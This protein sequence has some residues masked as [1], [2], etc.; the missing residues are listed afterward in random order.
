MAAEYLQQAMESTQEPEEEK[1]EAAPAQ[2]PAE[3]PVEPVVDPA[4]LQNITQTVQ[5][6][7][8][9]VADH[10]MNVTEIID[11]NEEE[12]AE[13]FHIIEEDETEELDEVENP[14]NAAGMLTQM[15]PGEQLPT[16]YQAECYLERYPDVLQHIGGTR[17]LTAAKMHWM[18]SGKD[19][20][21][22]MKCGLGKKA[23]MTDQ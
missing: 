13:Y 12:D 21:R 9:Q 23:G 14:D 15:W 8:M 22:T 17:D 6:L 11:G 3:G 2:E 10:S 7:E 20:G 4:A 18:T 1:K 16:D 5:A 19:E